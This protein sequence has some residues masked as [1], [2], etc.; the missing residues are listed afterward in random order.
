ML[1]PKPD[2]LR[3]LLAKQ[4]DSLKK[5]LKKLKQ[6]SPKNLDEQFNDLHE[7]AFESYDCLS[8]GN[9]CK[10]TSPM[11]FEKD[12]ER[13]AN[14][15]KL[16]PGDFVQQYLFLDTDGIYGMKST[17]CPFLDGE[18]YC[19]IYDHRPKACR[20]FPHTNHRKMHTHLHLAAKNMEICPA[21]YAIVQKI[22]AL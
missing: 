13:L 2:E 11:L 22:E 21:V 18:N 14:H 3:N 9:C 16:K 10:T 17:P 19:S 8:C 15:L 4:G 5:K 20:E 1:I 7:E 6:K 12:I